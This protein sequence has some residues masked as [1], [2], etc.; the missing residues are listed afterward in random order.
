VRLDIKV[1]AVAIA[2]EI[3]LAILAVFGGPHGALGGWP[4]TLQLP[5]ILVMLLLPGD[6]G[7]A[8]RAAAMIIIQICVWYAICLLI[9]RR[10]NRSQSPAT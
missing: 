4:W 9:R 7:F 10:M 1:L 5:G 3:G 6:G 8:W 2:I